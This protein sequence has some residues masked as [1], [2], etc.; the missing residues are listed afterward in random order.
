MDCFSG[1]TLGFV[2]Q[3]E[4]VSENF[5]WQLFD[6]SGRNNDDVFT[7]PSLFLACNWSPEPGETGASVNGTS[8]TICADAGQDPF[9]SMPTLI[10]GHEYLLMVSHRVN[11]D[12]GFQIHLTGGTA[13][14]TDPS[15]PSFVNARLG[16]EGR[17]I[18]VVLNKKMNCSSISADGSEFSID[19]PT[20]IASVTALNC[21]V[22]AQANVLVLSLSTPIMPGAY[23]L[24]V[25]NGSD[26]NTF[27]DK[28]GTSMAEGAA[29]PLLLPSTGPALPDS[30]RLQDCSSRTLRIPLSKPIQCNSIAAN[31]S[32]FS[33]SGP[34]AVNITGVTVTCNSANPVSITTSLIEL[35]LSAPITMAGD[36]R[37]TLNSGSDGNTLLDE[38]GQPLPAGVSM[39]FV[40]KASVSA[41]FTY[42]VRT[43]CKADSVFLFHDGNNGSNYW[44]WTLGNSPWANSQNPVIVFTGDAGMYR[45]GLLVSNGVCS[46]T[47]SVMITLGNKVSA[48]FDIPSIICP[49]DTMKVVNRSTGLIDTWHW[50][51]G[52]ANQSAL[53]DP[54]PVLFAMNG[55]ETSYT[56]T[57]H[58]MNTAAN[59][60]DSLSKNVLVLGSCF[61]AVPT[62]FTPNGDGL[63]DF[64]F[65]LNALKADNLQFRVY[66]RYGQVVFET[67]DWSRKWDGRVNGVL[68]ATGVYAWVLTFTN[69]ET[70]ER[71]FQKGTTALIRK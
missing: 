27:V 50:N 61:I 42:Q 29:T 18:V 10:Q 8:T 33:L 36:Y 46:D 7:D 68:Q 19:A 1:G 3:P 6:I 53:R 25:N 37:V 57:L 15:E 32:D 54:L 5:D 59:C 64:L 45:A 13:G 41:D 34:Q 11:S 60:R 43:S 2:I 35:D 23:T 21:N 40:A 26:G 52:N 20:T 4:D 28:C 30:I 12:A 22:E 24:T 63:N 14:V 16:C 67:R 71:V 17:E 48:S 55:R 44:T 70:G 31:G 51:F 39:P 47:S 38:C 62:A 58:T 65:P 49:E 69:R 9:S 66:N 56:V